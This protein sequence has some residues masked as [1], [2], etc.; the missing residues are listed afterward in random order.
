VTNSP[1]GIEVHP[2]N[3]LA[4][5]PDENITYEEESENENLENVEAVINQL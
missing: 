4:D 3:D 1:D 5:F 2:E